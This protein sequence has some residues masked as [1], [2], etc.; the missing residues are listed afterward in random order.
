[1]KAARGV[2]VQPLV[3]DWL[4]ATALPPGVRVRVDVDPYGFM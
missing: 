4:A 2:K 3:R 1:M